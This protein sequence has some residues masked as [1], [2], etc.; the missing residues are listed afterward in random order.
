PE[1][2]P[3][4]LASAEAVKVEVVEP[5]F[6][7]AN[8]DAA[9]EAQEDATKPTKL[10]S[11]DKIED[12][13]IEITAEL[14]AEKKENGDVDPDS[15]SVAEPRTE[16]NPGNQ[17]NG[18]ECEVSPAHSEANEDEDPRARLKAKRARARVRAKAR[19][20]A[21]A[22]GSTS[23]V[24]TGADTINGGASEQKKKPK[25]KARKVAQRE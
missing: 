6:S 23:V 25:K 4:P 16:S 20:A 10:D 13:A 14:A 11:S 3:D 1:G 5:T 8:G 12:S 21:E 19:K 2:K 18:T 24:A 15:I 22:E 17:K 9:E 7:E